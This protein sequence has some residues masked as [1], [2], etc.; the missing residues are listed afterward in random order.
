MVK[1][2]NEKY[3]KETIVMLKEAIRDEKDAIKTYQTIL[4]K[5]KDLDSDGIDKIT[6]ILNDE[7]DH[8]NILQEMIK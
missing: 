8:L 6:E 4:K 7:K 3:D 2:L 5:C 1:I